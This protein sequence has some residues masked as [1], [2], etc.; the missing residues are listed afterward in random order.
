MK[1][2]FEALTGIGV[3]GYLLT[4]LALDGEPKVLLYASA[5]LVAIGLLGRLVM[6]MMSSE[7]Q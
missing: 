1:K 6:A 7:E 5:V 4:K 2:V 3:I